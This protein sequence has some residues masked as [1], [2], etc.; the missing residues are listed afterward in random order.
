MEWHKNESKQATC[1]TGD[2]RGVP[3]AEAM[4]ELWRLFAGAILPENEA[5]DWDSIRAEFWP[6]SGRIIVFPAS[7][8]IDERIEKAGCQVCFPELQSAYDLLADAD[9]DDDAFGEQL[10]ALQDQW[11]NELE[12]AAR[13]SSLSSLRISFWEA[14]SAEPFREIELF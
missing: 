12:R 7:S 11:A 3:R 8:A 14:E 6:D 1:Y 10:A 5:V 2:A 13:A 4:T 9:I